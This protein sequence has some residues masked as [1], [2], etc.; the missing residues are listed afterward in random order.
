MIGSKVICINN[1][2]VYRGWEL[3]REGI[4]PGRTYELLAEISGVQN[5]PGKFYYITDD[6]GRTG[7]YNTEHFETLSSY[8][9]KKL[10][11]LLN[12]Q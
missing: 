11:E 2:Y 3:T 5:S 8:R 4:T 10:N 7:D 12:D 1:K 9:D 6:N